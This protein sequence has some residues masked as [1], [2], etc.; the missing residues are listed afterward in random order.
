M[1]SMLR[2]KLG[3]EGPTRL[4]IP[5]PL[6]EPDV[7]I[8]EVKLEIL[9]FGEGESKHMASVYIPML[10]GLGLQ[11]SSHLFPGKSWLARLDEFET[12]A[13]KRVTTLHRSHG[14]AAG[15]ELIGQD[16]RLSA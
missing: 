15:L 12:Y 7:T 16:P 14:K 11:P 9:E 10:S 8:E 2:D 4:V 3:P 13:K 1:F 6:T 5:D